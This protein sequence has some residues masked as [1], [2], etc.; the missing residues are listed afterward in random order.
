MKDAPIDTNPPRT[1]VRWGVVAVAVAG[2]AGISMVLGPG[3]EDEPPLPPELADEPDA[4]VEAGT[5]TQFR[6]DGGIEYRLRADGISHFDAAGR[7]TLQAPLLEL[8]DADGLPW[9]MESQRGEV[10]AAAGTDEERV[11]LRGDVTLTQDRGGG[12]Y[13]RIR[14]EAL[15]LYPARQQAKAEQTAMIETDTVSARVA[16]FEADLA[17][18]RLTLFSSASQRVSIVARPDQQ[19]AT[20]R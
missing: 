9:R 19:T 17:S 13:T 5:I 11:E 3:E 16:G 14:T 8:H 15:T 18:G 20:R 6:D 1:L 7:S 10:R 12:A 4:F 2:F